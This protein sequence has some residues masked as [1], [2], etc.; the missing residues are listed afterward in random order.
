M[1]HPSRALALIYR[2]LVRGKD[3]DERLELDA[4]LGDEDAKA[5]LQVNRREAIALMD[6]EIG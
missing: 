3:A 2:A 5:Q 1:M 4:K 6:A